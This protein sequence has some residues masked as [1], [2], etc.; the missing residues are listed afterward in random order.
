[1][2]EDWYRSTESLAL[3]EVQVHGGDVRLVI[4]KVSEKF[5]G[6][7][8]PFSWSLA[9]TQDTLWGSCSP[10][11]ILIIGGPACTRT[12]WTSLRCVFCEKNTPKPAPPKSVLSIK[13]IKPFKKWA[14]VATEFPDS[15]ANVSHNTQGAL[16]GLPLDVSNSI[17]QSNGK[18]KLQA[19]S[20]S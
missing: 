17:N 2:L 12:S 11:P 13:A 19:L 16:N 20:P 4:G 5:S 14:L 6:M 18:V 1:M 10:V 8:T 15:P 3:T 7:S 9:M